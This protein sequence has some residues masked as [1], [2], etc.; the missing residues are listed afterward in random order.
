MLQK[1]VRTMN[2]RFILDDREETDAEGKC[3]DTEQCELRDNARVR[4]DTH[5]GAVA[6]TAR[7]NLL[8]GVTKQIS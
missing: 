2:D 6:A 4:G 5:A 3:A 8:Q 1:V 7:H